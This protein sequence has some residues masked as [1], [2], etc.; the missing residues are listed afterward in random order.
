MSFPVKTCNHIAGDERVGSISL[1][2]FQYHVTVN[3][4][5]LFL[6]VLWVGLQC[7]IAAFSCHTHLLFVKVFVSSCDKIIWYTILQNWREPQN[8]KIAVSVF[9]PLMILNG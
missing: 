5:C 9:S 6:T 8:M 2:A 7:V 4:L 3:I 1:I